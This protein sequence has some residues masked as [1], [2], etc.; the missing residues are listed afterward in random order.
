[1]L[2]DLHGFETRENCFGDGERAAAREYDPFRDEPRDEDLVQVTHPSQCE[3]CGRELDAKGAHL[4]L[5]SLR[6]CLR[7]GVRR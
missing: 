7:N 1:M 2:I 3:Y 6:F 5:V 4:T